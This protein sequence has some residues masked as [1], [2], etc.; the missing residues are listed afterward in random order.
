MDIEE[1]KMR[2]RDI[3]ARA[4]DDESAHILEDSLYADFVRYVA[5]KSSGELAEMAKEILKTGDI[6]FSRWYA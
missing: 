1:C 4:C 6:K 3:S 5:E 2:V